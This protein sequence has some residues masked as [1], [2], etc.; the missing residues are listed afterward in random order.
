V[1]ID[2]FLAELKNVDFGQ[3]GNVKD[4]YRVLVPVGNF[5]EICLKLSTL[6]ALEIALVN[7]VLNTIS[8]CGRYP[9]YPSESLRVSDVVVE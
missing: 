2:S 7:G 9:F 4:D 8:I 1:T 6:I 3:L 5:P